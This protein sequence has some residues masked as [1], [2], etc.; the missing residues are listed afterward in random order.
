MYTILSN[1]LLSFIY[2]YKTLWYCKKEKK[3]H[4]LQWMHQGRTRKE[5]NF[6]LCVSKLQ[7]MIIIS[8][9]KSLIKHLTFDLFTKMTCK[10]IFPLLAKEIRVSCCSTYLLHLFTE[11]F[12]PVLLVTD[13]NK[14]T[15][16]LP[17]YAKTIKT[18]ITVSKLE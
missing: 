3:M 13:K 11:R 5:W 7:S 8:C 17:F 2:I 14:P 15:H 9:C 6:P 16:T 18:F 12:I 1:W 10:Y 4:F